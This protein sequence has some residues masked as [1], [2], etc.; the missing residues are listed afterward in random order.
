MI[1]FYCDRCGVE[2]KAIPHNQRTE[3]YRIKKVTRFNELSDAPDRDTTTVHL[4]DDCQ[5][6]LKNF[7]GNWKKN[8]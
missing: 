8:D 7:I 5:E 2:I 4:C 1:K 6:E 3:Y